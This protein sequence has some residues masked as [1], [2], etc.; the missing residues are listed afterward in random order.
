MSLIEENLNVL[1]AELLAERGLKAL[2]EVVLRRK[3]GR[4]EPDVLIELNGVRIVVEG[5]KP[6]MWDALVEQ[7]A[8]RLDDNVCDLCVMVEY[9]DIK[10]RKLVPN[11]LDVKEALLRGRFN[12]GFLSYVDRAGLERWTGVASKPEKYVDVSFDELLTYLMRVY[13]RVVREDVIGPVIKKMNEV[14]DEFAK[15]VS[16]LVDAERLKEVLELKET[17]KVPF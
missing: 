6:G 13:G 12:V 9:A 7:C 10:L 5:K 15:K 3:G 17:D 8:K 2:G 4:P 16:T 1:L 14:L 11:Q